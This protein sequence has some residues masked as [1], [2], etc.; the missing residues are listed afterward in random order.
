MSDTTEMAIADELREAAALLRKRGSEATP[1]PWHRPLNTRY[2]ASVRAPLPQGEQ[3]TWRDGI[4]PDTGEREP[5]TVVSAPVWSNGRHYRKRSGRD[6]EWIALMD[7]LLAE[8]LASWL[9]ETATRYDAEVIADQ[10][11]CPRCDEGHDH[12]TLLV[13]DGGCGGVLLD[14]GEGICECFAPALAVARV[15]NGTTS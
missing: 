11:E 13:H 2:K 14:V 8:P 5:C 6:L 10:P 4:D 7:P 15:L 1:G 12:G 9:E 3:G